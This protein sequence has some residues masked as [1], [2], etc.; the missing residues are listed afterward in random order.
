MP[1]S[2]YRPVSNHQEV[3]RGGRT[4][5]AMIGHTLGLTL[6]HC[7]TSIGPHRSHFVHSAGV[8]GSI[9]GP[10]ACGGDCCA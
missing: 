5:V 1:R 6:A 2:D 10:V 8:G 3:R 9:R 7:G 4:A